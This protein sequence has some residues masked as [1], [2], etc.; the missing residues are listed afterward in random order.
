MPYYA[1]LSFE[2]MDENNK[3][4]IYTKWFEFRDEEHWEMI[5]GDSYDSIGE[6][7]NSPQVSSHSCAT[8]P[9]GASKAPTK[10]LSIF[11][12]LKM[13]LCRF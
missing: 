6:L 9:L 10:V 13:I 3:D 4:S 8:G 5:E 12:G 11:K 1:Q 2:V 7:I